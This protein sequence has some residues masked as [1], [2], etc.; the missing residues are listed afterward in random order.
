MF[1]LLNTICTACPISQTDITTGLFMQSAILASLFAAQVREQCS[2]GHVH[3]ALA[4]K[5][6]AF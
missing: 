2:I 1:W 5:S 3:V 4:G 6:N